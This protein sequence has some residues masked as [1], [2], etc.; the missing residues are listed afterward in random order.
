M[1]KVQDKVLLTYTRP[2]VQMRRQLKIG[3]FGLVLGSG[4][5]RPFG[6]PNWRELV[7]RIA[8]DPRVSARYLLKTSKSSQASQTQMVFQHFRAQ[9]R[10]DAAPPKHHTLAFERRIKGLWREVIH[11]NLYR[12]EVEGDL[13]DQHP[14]I[15]KYLNIIR[16]SEMTVNYNFDDTIERMLAKRRS[17]EERKR[18]RGYETVWD[19]RLQ[20]QSRTGIIYHPN[21]YLP[22]NLLEDPSEELIFLEDHFGDQLLDTIAGYYAS[23]SHHL[24]K[25]T[26][27][28]I[29]LSLNDSTL[30][31]LLHQH[32]AINPGHYHYYVAFV[33]DGGVPDK[34]GREAIVN[35]NFQVYNLITLFLTAEEIAA[36]GHWI[37]L[38]EQDFRHAA[39]EL[40]VNVKF[41]Y[42]VTGVVGAGKT[43]TVAYF[44]SLVPHDEWFEPRSALLAKPFTALTGREKDEVDDWIAGQFG[45]KNTA[46]LDQHEGIHII[47]RSPI[48]P[49][50]FTETAE[51][52]E[53]AKRLVKAI[54][55][56]KSRRRTQPGHMIF[57]VADGNEF[58]AR[59]AGRHKF[60]EPDYYE[61][62]QDH[63]ETILGEHGVTRIDVRGLSIHDVVK[64]AAHII[65]LQEYTEVDLHQIL[66]DIKDGII[67]GDG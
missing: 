25:N 13:E 8:A 45:L 22:K 17:Q 2:I 42:Y 9:T 38:D 3:R 11:D 44:R 31:H 40:G 12:D 50:T 36:L 52:P 47:D 41:T 4:V 18:G 61:M 51:W 37:N 43:T 59:A 16:R 58:A 33:R 65:H 7:E 23:L 19:A 57:L 20:F 54:S 29:G 55:P 26:C 66:L 48:D 60:G 35:A 10:L 1:S 53:K 56:G 32:A 62:M 15:G 28:F 5:S 34:E 67:L 27:L 21:G 63:F 64:Q 14:Y 39:E 30:K 49:I 6:I 46:L 24:S